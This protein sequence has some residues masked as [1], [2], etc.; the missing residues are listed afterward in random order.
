MIGCAARRGLRGQR[1]LRQAG[2]GKSRKRIHCDRQLCRRPSRDETRERRSSVRTPGALAERRISPRNR[3]AAPADKCER[4]PHRM[5]CGS[6]HWTRARRTTPCRFPLRH[7]G[8]EP[9]AIL[10]AESATFGRR[11]NCRIARAVNERHVAKRVQ[12][13]EVRQFERQEAAICIVGEGDAAIEI[14][15]R[16]ER[17]RSLRRGRD[18][19]TA[20][21]SSRLRDHHIGHM[22]RD[23]EAARGVGFVS[24]A[25]DVEFVAGRILRVERCQLF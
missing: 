3:L 12:P 16:V 10:C 5:K 13:S 19:R 24:G 22:A 9:C 4:D 11:Q 18:I 21:E 23:D 14:E 2:P 17:K 1:R 25:A 20:I 6:R 8:V 7:R 15:D